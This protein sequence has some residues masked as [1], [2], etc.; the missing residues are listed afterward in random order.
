MSWLKLNVMFLLVFCIMCCVRL[1]ELR[2]YIVVLLVEVILRILV[3]RLDRWIM[4]LGLV[5]WL[6]VV[7]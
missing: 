4:F 2:L 1:I 7:L 3:Y 5:V 6:L